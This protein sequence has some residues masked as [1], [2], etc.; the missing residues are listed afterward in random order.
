MF[1]P[2]DLIRVPSDVGLYK[3]HEN[4]VE[5]Y[6]KTNKPKMGIFVEYESSNECKVNLDGENWTVSLQFIRI[7]ELKNDKIDTNNKI[8]P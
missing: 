4:S 6:R 7:M 5:F 2:G 8:K 1:M 3:Y